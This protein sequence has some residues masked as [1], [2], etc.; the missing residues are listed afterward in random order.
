ME[1]KMKN[2]VVF[3]LPAKSG[4]KKDGEQMKYSSFYVLVRDLARG[5]TFSV[6]RVRDHEDG[7]FRIFTIYDPRHPWQGELVF[8]T[9]HGVRG[10]WYHGNCWP[11]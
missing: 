4:W 8:E 6:G 3:N 7:P 11:L 2:L 10:W 5:Q 1:N 9:N